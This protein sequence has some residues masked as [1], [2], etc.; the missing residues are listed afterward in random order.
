M[1][2][3]A[4]VSFSSRAARKKE[5]LTYPGLGDPKEG[6]EER[7]EAGSEPEESSLPAPVPFLCRQ[8]P[9][10]DLIGN[11]RDENIRSSSQDDGVCSKSR[12]WHFGNHGV[13]SGSERQFESQIDDDHHSCDTGG[14]VGTAYNTEDTDNNLSDADGG[15]TE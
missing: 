13:T 1:T 8:L 12:V 9:G 15:G 5:N 11:N 14:D 2:G 3:S 6:V 7:E 10:D 4:R